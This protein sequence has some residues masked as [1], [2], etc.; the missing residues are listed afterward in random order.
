MRSVKLAA[1]LLL[2]PKM[3][4]ATANYVENTYHNMIKSF[5]AMGRTWLPI[6]PTAA[7]LDFKIQ[8][9]SLNISFFYDSE[10]FLYQSR[11]LH[12]DLK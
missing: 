3:R 6:W 2:M 1:I 7:I 10:G 12:Y 5:W 11:H 9:A 4:S 8:I